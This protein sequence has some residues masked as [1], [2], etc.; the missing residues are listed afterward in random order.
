MIISKEQTKEDK[1]LLSKVSKMPGRSIGRSAWLCDVGQKLRKIQGTTCQD[2]Y[3][4][5]GMYNMPNVK[6]AMERREVFFNALDFVPR[7]I[8]VLNTL[9]KPEFR[10][11]DSGD[12]GSVPMAL[13]ILDVCE[14]TPDKMHWIPSREFEKWGE[15]LE[16]RNNVLPK[17]V[18][19]RMSAHKRDGKPPKAWANTST[20]AE[21]AAPIGHE[22]P[23]PKQGNKCGPCR[24]CWD[25]TV[26]NVSYH[27]H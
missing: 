10:W 11:F 6:A 12:V 18:T 24:A 21:H 13:N 3:A 25:N 7:M 9:R 5:K 2:C 14:A 16:I 26:P 1:K 27:K 4:C 15:A 17:N 22:C 8:A 23:A 20:V 19:L